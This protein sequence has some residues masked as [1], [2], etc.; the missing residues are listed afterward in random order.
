MQLVLPFTVSEDFAAN[1]NT[2]TGRPECRARVNPPGAVNRWTVTIPHHSQTHF[3]LREVFTMQRFSARRPE[4]VLE[5]RL[6]CYRKLADARRH[7]FQ[8]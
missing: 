5:L 7:A 3:S 8:L 1:I 6:H 4:I 2:D